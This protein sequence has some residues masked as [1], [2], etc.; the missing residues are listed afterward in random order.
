[1]EFRILG[2]LEVS[3]NGRPLT[4]SAPRERALLAMLLLRAN[5]VV[6]T[7]QLIDWLWGEA[8]PSTAKATLQTYV[9]R[10]RRLLRPPGDP[11]LNAVL[12]TCPPGYL[13]KVEPGQ[14]DL[15]RFDRL[16]DE[17][18]AAMAEEA[19]SGART[20]CT[21]RWRCGAGRRSPT[22]PPTSCDGSRRRGSR[23]AR[24]SGNRCGQ[25]YATHSLAGLYVDQGRFDEAMAC[26]RRCLAVFRQLG[27]RRWEA[28]TLLSLGIAHR[29]QG[30]FDEA[31]GRFGQCLPIFRQLGDRLGEA[32]ALRNLGRA[33]LARAAS[34]RRGT[35]ST[36]A[37]RR[38]ASCTTP[39]ARRR[40]C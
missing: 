5:R 33:H 8:P 11:P 32:Y 16:L 9:L 7:D 31:A 35:A 13:L 24:R 21:R 1:M 3:P 39:S 6:S 25:A 12:V 22:W 26:F 40:R 10:L 37:W 18:R 30:R 29:D 38:S 14:L 17:A 34:A 23:S 28:Y 19:P 2:P 15:H 27:D 20:S 36:R 4:P